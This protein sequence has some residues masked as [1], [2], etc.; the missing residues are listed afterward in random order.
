MKTVQINTTCGVGSTGKICKSISEALD[1]RNI[2]NYILFSSGKCKDKNSI[3]FSSDGY[4][5]IQ[6]LKSRIF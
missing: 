6:A 5:K 4:A 3:S 2:E 1:K